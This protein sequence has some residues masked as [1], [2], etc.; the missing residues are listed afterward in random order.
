M[1]SGY[2]VNLHEM[3]ANRI[4]KPDNNRALFLKVI[5]TFDIFHHSFQVGACVYLEVFNVFDLFFG[6]SNMHMNLLVP[7]NVQVLV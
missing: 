2:P 4:E 7:L 1:G 5:Y 3:Q 6:T